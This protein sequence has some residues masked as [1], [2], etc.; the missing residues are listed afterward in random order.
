MATLWNE[1]TQKT[2]SI[3]VGLEV[4]MFT[5]VQMLLVNNMMWTY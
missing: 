5:K 4:T 1:G 3:Q 2:K